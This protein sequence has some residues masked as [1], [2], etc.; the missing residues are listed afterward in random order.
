MF[1]NLDL[2]IQWNQDINIQPTRSIFSK[3]LILWN[4][5]KPFYKLLFD[6][7]KSRLKEHFA[8]KDPDYY[9]RSTIPIHWL[10]SLTGT[11]LY[12]IIDLIRPY[13]PMITDKEKTDSIRNVVEFYLQTGFKILPKTF[14][15]KSRIVYNNSCHPIAMDMIL[16]DDVR[17]NICMTNDTEYDT[18]RFFH[19]I[20]HVY[21]YLASRNRVNL[22]KLNHNSA[23][24]ESIGEVMRLLWNGCQLSSKMTNTKFTNLKEQRINMLMEEA[25]SSFVMIPYGI[26]LELWRQRAFTILSNASIK[27]L[28]NDYWKIRE[29][30]Q[31]IRSPIDDDQLNMQLD[32]L[33]KFH[34][35]NFIPYL[36]YVFGT[37]VM[38]QFQEKICSKIRKQNHLFLVECCPKDITDL[39]IFR[40]VFCTN[41]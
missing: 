26:S 31:G 1:F 37:I 16:E 8:S 2:W 25:V 11:R 19:E 23:V 40:L 33:L 7:I 15:K 28:N 35:G 36:R 10:R 22:Y 30:I 41:K 9:N 18:R 29:K 34:I 38:H 4:Q 27:E 32:P 39:D 3:I 6:Y 5:A 13:K 24:H 12:T 20:G 14:W 21:Y 17:V